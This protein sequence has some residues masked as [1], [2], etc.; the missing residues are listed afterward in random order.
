MFIQCELYIEDK[1]EAMYSG[2]VAALTRSICKRRKEIGIHGL[3][4]ITVKVF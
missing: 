3:S 2:T 4:E 1:E